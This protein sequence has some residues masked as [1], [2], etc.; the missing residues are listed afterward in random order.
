MSCTELQ[1][2]VCLHYQ[3]TN[4][5]TWRQWLLTSELASMSA[6]YPCHLI[7]S[8][9]WWPTFCRG[10]A[11]AWMFTRNL[12]A[13][14]VVYFG[15]PCTVVY[16]HVLVQVQVSI[17]NQIVFCAVFTRINELVF[18]KVM[19]TIRENNNNEKTCKTNVILGPVI[20]MVPYLIIDNNYVIY[21]IGW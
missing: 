9:Q 16:L 3:A 11:L 1:W 14:L 5:F 10:V 18:W 7:K 21:V 20:V 13:F 15:F 19:A 17:Y 6:Y 4:N 12:F 2:T 8:S